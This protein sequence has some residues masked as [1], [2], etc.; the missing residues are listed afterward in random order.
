MTGVPRRAAVLGHPISHSL[1]PVLHRAAYAALGLDWTY[2]AIDVDEGDLASFLATAGDEWAGLSLTM[3]L[4]LEAARLAHFIEPQA[5]LVGPV[6]TLISSGLGEY[7]QWVGANTDIYG[8]S[9]AL[10]EAGVAA[11]ASAVIVGGGATATS[12][13][14]ALGSMGVQNPVVLVRDRARAGGLIRV[15]TRMGL[16]PTLLG[17]DTDHAVVALAG[18]DAVVSTIPADAGGLLG[19]RLAAKEV[20]VTGCLLDV[21]YSPPVTP[22]AAAWAGCGG[23]AVSGTRMLLHQAGE[24]VRLITGR[25]PPIGAMD[26]ALAKALNAA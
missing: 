10:R 20:V 8:V 2:E 9:Q 13:L 16:R 18:A 17:I 24:Q 19:A 14:A 3:P 6:N 12:A 23:F 1:S 4:K 11:P 22:L 25:Q 5:K 21:V 7:R 15:A 26:A